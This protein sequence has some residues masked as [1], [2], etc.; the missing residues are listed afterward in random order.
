MTHLPLTD[1]P[2]RALFSVESDLLP[3]VEK[4][5]QPITFTQARTVADATLQDGNVK[6]AHIIC[7][8]ANDDLVLVRFGNKGGIAC[9]WNFTTGKKTFR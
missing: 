2:L 4:R 1:S 8:R 5:T 3:I 7:L 9:L 6:A